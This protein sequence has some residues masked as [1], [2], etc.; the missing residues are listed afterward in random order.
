MYHNFLIHSSADGPLGYFLVLAIAPILLPREFYGQRSLAGYSPWGHKESDMTEH[1]TQG[2]QWRRRGGGH[3]CWAGPTFRPP[4]WCPRAPRLWNGCGPSL[5]PQLCRPP[6]ASS[7]VP[8][9]RSWQ[10]PRGW[11]SMVKAWALA[12]ILSS[13]VRCSVSHSSLWATVSSSVKP[14]GRC[15]HHR[16]VTEAWVSSHI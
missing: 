8:Y 3:T 14:R 12:S 1:L 4:V 2:R 13:A 5:L 9:A 6:P 10:G 15:L 7:R 16:I 11:D